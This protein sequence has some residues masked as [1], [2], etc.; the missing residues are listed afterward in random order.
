[1]ANIK[2]LYEKVKAGE[3][4][5]SKLT[6]IMDND[7]TGFYVGDEKAIEDFSGNGYCDIED[8]YPL[9][10]PKATVEWC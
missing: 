8:L 6:I 7:N 5:E 4:D 10:F 1:M 3:I 2:E 9:L